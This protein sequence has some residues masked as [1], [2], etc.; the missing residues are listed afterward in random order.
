MWNITFIPNPNKLTVMAAI[1]IANPFSK[2]D[3][4]LAAK[5]SKKK[6][7][8]TK[9]NLNETRKPNK[10]KANR[11]INLPPPFLNTKI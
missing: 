11:F 2:S 1:A 10:A 3:G 8:P 6:Y 7:T 5:Y 9:N 4:A